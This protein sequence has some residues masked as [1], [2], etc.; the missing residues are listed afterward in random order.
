M[1]SAPAG[2]ALRSL[3]ALFCFLTSVTPTETVPRC[4]SR[5]RRMSN[6][7]SYQSIDCVC[8]LTCHEPFLRSAIACHL[9]T[10]LYSKITAVMMKPTFV[11]FLVTDR[12]TTTILLYTRRCHDQSSESHRTSAKFPLWS[13]IVQDRTAVHSMSHDRGRCG[14]PVVVGSRHLP[15]LLWNQLD[16]HVQ[17]ITGY[18]VAFSSISSVVYSMSGTS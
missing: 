7:H 10:V 5:P 3:F 16:A 12:Q 8:R 4:A 1:Y 6:S 17:L 14:V 15:S 9:G 2:D 13:I 11:I 18:P